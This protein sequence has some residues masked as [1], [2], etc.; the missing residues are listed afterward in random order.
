MID[1]KMKQDILST[2][3]IRI[4]HCGISAFSIGVMCLKKASI[5]LHEKVNV[6]LVQPWVA[7]DP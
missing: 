6:S 5:N 2:A 3:S 4:E 1:L 7:M